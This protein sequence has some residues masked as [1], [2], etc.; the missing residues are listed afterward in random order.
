[1][2]HALDLWLNLLLFA[3]AA[4]AVWVAG[5]RL[6][7]YTD[8]IADATGIGKAFLGLVLLAG[9]TS[10]PELATTL[11][12]AAAGN[13]ALAITNLFGGIA[14]QTAVLAVADLTLTHGALTW[15]APRP[16]LLLEGNLLIVLLALAVAG[17]V[18]GEAV[19]FLGIGLW[20]VLLLAGYLLALWSLQR[21]EGKGVW[22]PV[23]P[24]RAPEVPRRHAERY[25]D[26]SLRRLLLAFAAASAV[27]TA[28]GAALA[29]SADAI[30][31][32]SG[33][34]A[35]FVGASLLAASTSLPEVSTT[36]A[37]VRIGAYAMAIS[38]IFGS[39]MIMVAL[40]LPADAL[41]REGPILAA[42]DDAA[43]FTVAVGIAVTALYLIG[44]IERRNYTVLRMGVDSLAVLV[45]YVGSLIGLYFLR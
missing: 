18:A 45:L 13:A 40:L 26:W 35:S 23:D 25:S 24:P 36:L 31:A 22:Q 32:Q 34:G 38:N 30:A 19:A 28:A 20:P 44:M 15:F 6:S 5:S 37:A 8:A 21:Y 3:V 33:L 12:A 9:A 41:Y 7:G 17:I 4:A 27:I 2:F 1:M 11:T 43:L 14:M 29:M 39:N 42:A 10:L 16:V